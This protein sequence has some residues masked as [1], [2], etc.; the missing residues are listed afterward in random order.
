MCNNVECL[1]LK[2][3]NACLITDI[4]PEAVA[5]ATRDMLVLYSYEVLLAGD[6]PGGITTT[7]LQLPDLVLC[8]TD[9]SGTDGLA[10]LEILRQAALAGTATESLIRILSE[11][12]QEKLLSVRGSSITLQRPG[13]L[14]EIAYH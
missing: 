8:D 13:R 11:F 1:L 5:T 3:R 9:M 4:D 6:G 2:E 10:V 7:R 12:R 14:D